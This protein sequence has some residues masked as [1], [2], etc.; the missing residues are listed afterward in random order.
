DL[1]DYY[2]AGTF[3]GGL[4]GTSE[5]LGAEARF[6]EQ[7][8]QHSIEVNFVSTAAGKAL[9][10]CLLRPNSGATRAQQKARLMALMRTPSSAGF[11]LLLSG[12]EPAIAE[13]LLQRATLQGIC[14]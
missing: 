8:K 13:D 2:R 7:L 14:P 11:A 12:Q 3:T 10:A 1:E 6:V 9:N 5:T 4:L